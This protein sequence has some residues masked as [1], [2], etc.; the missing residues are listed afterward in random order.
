MPR[1]PP[2]SLMGAG[3]GAWT[4]IIDG[5]AIVELVI[6]AFTMFYFAVGYRFFPEFYR[7]AMT[8]LMMIAVGLLFGLTFV[9]PIIYMTGFNISIAA[10][11]LASLSMVLAV[12]NIFG[13][14][15]SSPHASLVVELNP[16]WLILFYFGV[17]VAE[18]TCFT[19]GFFSTLA[20][21]NWPGT[22]WTQMIVKSLLF[23]GYHEFVARQVFGLP[24]FQTSYSLMLYF[25]SMIFTVAYY[26]TRHFS[27]P[28]T[29]HGLLN[30][31]VQA[32]SIGVLRV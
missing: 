9:Q 21:M 31:I 30:A 7:P 14:L 10:I 22:P 17:G 19:L 3:K 13:A 1:Q 11:A 27:V 25:G 24:V 5:L 18:E 32:V 2:S 12:E 6:A 4:P 20:K 28:A 26:Y 29:A 16:F 23:V 8:M 15:P